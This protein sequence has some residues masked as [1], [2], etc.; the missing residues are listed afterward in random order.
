MG[1][2]ALARLAR[3]F[4]A[5]WLGRP[6]SPTR[7]VLALTRRCNQRCAACRIWE[8]PSAGEE[9]RPDEIALMCRS[10]P[11]LTWLDVTGGEIFLRPDVDAVFDA[12]ARGL[13][14]LAVLHFPTNGSLPERALEIATSFRN[15]RPEVELIVTVSIDG[16]RDVHDAVRGVPGAF[17]RAIRTLRLLRALPGVRAVAG[18][19]VGVH[20]LD[21]LDDTL[22]AIRAAIPDLGPRD[23][24]WNLVQESPHYFAN[25]GRVAVPVDAADRVR[26]HRLRRGIPRGAMDLMEWA[27]LVLLEARLRGRE[28]PFP[29]QAL[30]SACHVAADG[31]V[32]PCHVWDRPIGSLRDAGMR[33]DR[34]WS[35]AEAL[36]ARQ[37]AVERACGGCFTPCEAYPAIAGA[38]VRAAVAIALELAGIG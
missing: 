17:D 31:T 11:G 28:I 18:T 20:N 34:A 10:L 35:S 23:W 33:M 6:G 24:H 16:P 26:A 3:G 21:A 22:P 4:A 7:M 36:A 9:L 29:C 13:P 30:H 25:V 2:I 8:K 12:L 19:T 32:F 1:P 38:P 37:G 27:F 5:G 14:S 15:A